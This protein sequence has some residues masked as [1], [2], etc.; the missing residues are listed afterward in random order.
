MPTS[1]HERLC[2][3]MVTAASLLT[4]SNH[5]GPGE[6]TRVLRAQMELR[7]CDQ[8]GAGSDDATSAS[9]EPGIVTWLNLPGVSLGRGGRYTYDLMLGHVHTLTDIERLRIDKLG[10]NDLC[11]SEIRLLVNGQPI[12]ARRFADG[13]W[14]VTSLEISGTELR[15]NSLWAAYHW[16]FSEWVASTGAA[17][18]HGEVVQRLQGSVGTA[19]HDAGLRWDSGAAAPLLA[20]RRNASTIAV[21]AELV[22]PRPYWVNDH[23]ELTFDLSVCTRNRAEAAV[24]SVL[25]RRVRH[26]YSFAASA[27][28]ADYQ[29]VLDVLRSR[30]IASRPIALAGDVCPEV[31]EE[32]NVVYSP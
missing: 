8:R 25:I 27:S 1:Y 30:L 20:S 32:G 16:S 10:D 29:R 26:W 17:I 11:I 12:F 23:V 19:I 6:G 21:A 9:I 7:I 14:L 18:S 22:R 2:L 13:L 5:S 15:A 31:D 3:A 24:Q 4:P 28:T